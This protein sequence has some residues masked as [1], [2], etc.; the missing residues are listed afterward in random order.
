MQDHSFFSVG[1]TIMLNFL[2]FVLTRPA[3]FVCGLPVE[4]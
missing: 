3:V 2:D 1:V 4:L